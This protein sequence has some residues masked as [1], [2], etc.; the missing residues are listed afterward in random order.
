MKNLVK[1]SLLISLMF[2]SL[3]LINCSDNEEDMG[4]KEKSTKELDL[5]FIYDLDFMDKNKINQIEVELDTDGDK[6]YTLHFDQELN[7]KAMVLPGKD[8]DCEDKECIGKEMK[9]C[10][11]NGGDKV[12]LTKKKETG[13]MNVKCE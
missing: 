4:I 5:S 10:L 11:D 7:I 13:K 6:I 9:E 1:I 2:F 8:I 12:T 3:I